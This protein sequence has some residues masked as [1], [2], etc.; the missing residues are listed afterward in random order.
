MYETDA[1]YFKERAFFVEGAWA[2]LTSTHSATSLA[3]ATATAPIIPTDAPADAD[4]TP[5]HSHN[6]A[7][8]GRVT[9]T[10]RHIAARRHTRPT[11]ADTRRRKPTH[12]T[13]QAPYAMRHTFATAHPRIVV[14]PQR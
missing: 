2:K 7:V 14:L 9:T 4:A 5:F 10:T 8:P 1:D 13:R 6:H 3:M 12:A 11:H